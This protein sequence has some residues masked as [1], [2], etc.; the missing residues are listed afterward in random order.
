MEFNK[1]M[2]NFY[3]VMFSYGTNSN[4]MKILNSYAKE[5]FNMKINDNYMD[6]INEYKDYVFLQ[7]VINDYKKADSQ[8]SFDEFFKTN[9]VR[10]IETLKNLSIEQKIL[11]ELLF[12]EDNYY[13]VHD[14]IRELIL[15]NNSSDMNV[16][17]GKYAMLFFDK[18]F[19]QEE[20]S[21]IINKLLPVVKD[22]NNQEFTD[23]INKFFLKE[24]VNLLN[25]D[26]IQALSKLFKNINTISVLNNFVQCLQTT[27]FDEFH[28]II[29]N[30]MLDKLINFYYIVSYHNDYYSQLASIT[31]AIPKED[32]SK[33]FNALLSHIKDAKDLSDSLLQISNK[34]KYILLPQDVYDSIWN[35]FIQVEMEDNS[36]K[37]H[38]FSLAKEVFKEE[39]YKSKLNAAI[40]MDDLVR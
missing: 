2:I 12:P 39:P 16:Y 11:I 9:N 14:Y 20:Y 30:T 40:L 34:Y 13:N 26:N 7:L 18:E 17:L 28:P 25:E 6:I 15:D 10:N 38:I 1:K 3:F 8:F 35:K 23:Y 33:L 5:L 36:T 19:T 4:D 24:Y 32:I 27:D 22:K 21:I 37:E 31:S 29:Y